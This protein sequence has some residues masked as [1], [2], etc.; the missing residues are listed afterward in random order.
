MT[1]SRFQGTTKGA[2]DQAKS[3]G[4]ALRALGYDVKREKVETVPW[5]PA[6]QVRI[7]RPSAYFEAHLALDGDER[8]IRDFSTR[9]AI[10]LSRNTM[11]KGRHSLMM[12]TYRVDAHEITSERFQDKVLWLYEEAI[13][14]GI[15]VMEK[16]LTEYSI[17]DTN[18]RHDAEWI[19][20]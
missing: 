19:S 15:T 9:N 20:G 18:E 2:I 6:A 10:H 14:N 7:I 11:K 16:P 8:L 12:G 3:L 5:H 13:R 1:S 4:R 17:F